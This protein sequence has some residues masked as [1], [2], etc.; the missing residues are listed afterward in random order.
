MAI[1]VHGDGNVLSTA[2]M[3]VLACLNEK[4]LEYEYVPVDMKAGDHKKEPFLSL[5]VSIFFKLGLKCLFSN[6]YV[7]LFGL[8]SHLVRFLPL[9]ME[10]WSCLVKAQK[11]LILALL[12]I[13]LK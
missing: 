2:A 1:K 6:L 10:N 4:E 3:R 8:C 5:N 11:E 13:F 12:N 7:S 9:K